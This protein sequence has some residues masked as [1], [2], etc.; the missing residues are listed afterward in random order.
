M[1]IVACHLAARALELPCR[2]RNTPIAIP[3]NDHLLSPSPDSELSVTLQSALYTTNAKTEEKVT[4]GSRAGSIGD[5]AFG[6]QGGEP[7][8]CVHRRDDVL[9]LLQVRSFVAGD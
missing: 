3:V 8:L 6:A 2:Q 9:D 5:C 4:S 7:L 1:R